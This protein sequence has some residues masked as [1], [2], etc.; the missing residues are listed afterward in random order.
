MAKNPKL[1]EKRPFSH[2]WEVVGLLEPYEKRSLFVVFIG[3][4]VMAL[5]QIIGVGSVLPFM[6]VAAKPEVIHTNEYLSWAY[7]AFGFSSDT[8]FLVVLGIGV[9][10]FLVTTNLAK[11]VLHYMKVRFTT[12]RQFTLGRKL[13]E[14]YLRQHY[15]FFL[16]RN[17]HEFVKNIRGEV[18]TMIQGTLMQFVE[19]LTKSIQVI[20]LTVFLF[21]VNPLS[22]LAISLALIVI[23]GLVYTIMRRPLKRL[24]EERFDLVRD[25][26][27]ILSE[28]F[29]GI[30]E[31]KLMGIER[32]FLDEFAVP[33]KRLARNKT[34]SE[35]LGD[36]PQFM[37]EAIA[38]SSIMLFVLLSILRYGSFA[39]AAASVT[40]Y[41]YAGYR[42]IPAIQ[43]TFK[44]VTKLRYSAPTAAKMLEE[45]DNVHNAPPLPKRV[46]ERISFLNEIALDHLWFTYPKSEKPV[47]QDIAINIAANSTV[48]F[49]GKTGSGKTTLV[50]IILGLHRP[51]Q[52]RILVDGKEV[53]DELV[54]NWQLN[55]GYVP[56]SIY[57]SNNTL[58][59]NIAYGVPKDEIDMEA[60]E[61]AAH[62]AQLDEFVE[63]DLPEKYQTFVGERGVRLS[64]GQRQRVGIARALYRNPPILVLDEATSALDGHTEE[65]VMHA[66]DTLMGTKTIIM[67]AHRL[68][69]LEKCDSI[70]LMKKGKIVD[71]GSYSDLLER[72]PYFSK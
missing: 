29:W 69:T 21:V 19:L 30:K 45:Y 22:T 40:L 68:S 20:L 49:A 1:Q 10:V 71:A 6:A 37:L 26:A 61:R 58:A 23:Y 66:I 38:F 11:V 72:N 13:M 53:T 33:A 8:N 28:S 55:L 50:D 14:Y 32:V 47:L 25:Q 43:G 42:M 56:Q 63:S 18:T 60:V 44:A 54:R 34:T 57:L 16:H 35:I 64:G 67:I 3:A 46:S 65:A 48:G 15:P 24:G 41:A 2:V 70:Y 27:R 5:I 9:L 59:A 4:V 51:Q 62:M 39:E 7:N 31:V 36:I 17:S 52:G 12:M